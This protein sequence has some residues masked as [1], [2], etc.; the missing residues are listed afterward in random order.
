LGTKKCLR[1]LI[2]HLKGGGGRNNN[3]ERGQGKRLLKPS[4]RKKGERSQPEKKFAYKTD[5][6]RKK[7]LRTEKL[8]RVHK[9]RSLKQGMRT[10]GTLPGV[11]K[12]GTHE[13]TQNLT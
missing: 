11:S 12:K 4:A 1:G 13:R 3:G 5:N 7:A 6:K 2:P 10:G 8:V 9:H